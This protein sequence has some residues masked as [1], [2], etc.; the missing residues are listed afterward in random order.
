M[1]P[2]PYW[3]RRLVIAPL[4]VALG[5]AALIL[6]PIELL[7]FLALVALLPHVRTVRVIWLVLVYL[8]WD[9]AAIVVLFILWIASGF[10]W[11][12]RSPAFRRAH[13]RV[14]AIAL[15]VLFWVFGA[16]LRLKI[17]AAGADVEDDPQASV[18]TVFAPGTPLIVASRHAG[19]GDSFILIHA[20]LNRVHRM[21]RIVLAQKLQWDPAIDILLSRV[22]TRFIRPAGFGPT[23]IGGGAHVEAEIGQLATDMASDDAL[24][25]FPE[26]GNFTPRRRRSRIERLRAAGREQMAERAESLANVMAPHPGGVR[27]ALEASDADVVF[28]AHTGLEDLVTLRDMWRALPMDKQITLRAWRVPRSEI[29][30][31]KDAQAAWLFEWFA[32]IDDWISAHA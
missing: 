2:P 31:D 4:V 23:K 14:A 26:G 8:I 7:I 11:K 5:G 6:I 30:D 15:G 27:A 12:L 16:S 22:P 20:L 10:G 24:V 17:V 19:P 32:R 18:D 13:Y 9:A 3:V 28:V 25:I 21:P 29:P 1:R